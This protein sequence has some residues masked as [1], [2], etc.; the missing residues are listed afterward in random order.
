VELGEV[1]IM[2]NTMNLSETFIIALG[3]M[4]VVFAVLVL[5]TISLVVKLSRMIIEGQTGSTKESSVAESYVNN[6]SSA[7]IAL[8]N[9]ND[10]D[11]E[12]D[13][14]VVAL[15]ASA[16]A[17]SDKPDSHFHISKITRTK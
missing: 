11:D 10:S 6:N 12:E 5:Y 17:A 16:L 14:L 3:G 8:Q 2:G 9:F 7:Q 15:A 4:V 13:R 1:K